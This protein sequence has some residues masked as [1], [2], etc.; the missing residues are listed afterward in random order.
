VTTWYNKE[1]PSGYLIEGKWNGNRYR[2]EKMIGVGSNGAVYL[3]R[4]GSTLLALKAGFDSVDLQ[5]EVNVLKKLQDGSPSKNKYLVDV[6]D[7]ELSGEKIPF[8]VMRYIK[9]K[10][11]EQHIAERGADWIYPIG[12]RLLAQLGELHAQDLVFGD[13]KPE[14]VMITGNGGVELIDYGGVTP[15]GRSVRQF[16]ELYDRGF[17]NCGSRVAD[18]AYDWFAFAVMCIKVCDSSSRFHDAGKLLPQ[19][20]NEDLLYE[21]IRQ[22][23]ALQ[24]MEPFLHQAIQGRLESY[25]QAAALWKRCIH[26]HVKRTARRAGGRWIHLAFLASLALCVST[27]IYFWSS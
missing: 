23:P 2:V 13:L 10:H 19:N 7:L 11:L 9:G 27:V 14:N 8:Y 17:W 5:L 15:K 26:S 4:R 25:G 16:T 22:T 6:D 20:R 12:Q 1:F 18:E 24:R 21:A 3:V